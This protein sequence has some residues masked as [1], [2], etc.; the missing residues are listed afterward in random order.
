MAEDLDMVHMIAKLGNKTRR[1]GTCLLH[2]ETQQ[3]FFFQNHMT[4]IIT[5][6]AR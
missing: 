6:S 5:I 1:L 3:D 2:P 4:E